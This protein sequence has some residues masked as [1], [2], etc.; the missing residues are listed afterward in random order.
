MELITDHSNLPHDSFVATIGFFDGVHVGHRFL[1]QQLKDK[2][3]FYGKKSL[4]ISFDVHPK[5]VLCSDYHPP[6]LTTNEEKIA[7]LDQLGIDAC[8]FLHFDKE[9]ANLSASEF[10]KTIIKDELGVHTLLIGYDHRFGKN[11]KEGFDE[12]V[13]Y[14]KAL[15][16]NVISIEPYE[17]GDSHASSS[18]VRKLL[19]EG[20]VEEANQ[21][22]SYS[23][24]LSGIVV[25]GKKMGHQLGFPTANVSVESEKLIPCEGIYAVDVFIENALYRGMLNIGYS[26]TVSNEQILGIEVHIFN[27]NKDIYGGE[28]SISF[29]KRIRDEVKFESKE[30]LMIQ[31]QKDKDYISNLNLS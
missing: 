10:L 28:I 19:S 15:N 7:I 31:L 6:L 11:R 30:A 25:A 16:L 12:Y 18:L 3:M 26:P 5:T 22:L 13:E 9:M 17:E 20:K 27:F 14:G 1:L 23:Y 2:A 24:T 4:V 21:F 8:Y 29:L